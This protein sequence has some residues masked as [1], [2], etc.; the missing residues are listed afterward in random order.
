MPLR[1]GVH[2]CTGC[3]LSTAEINR[4]TGDTR[5]L[6]DTIEDASVPDPYVGLVLD[7]KYELVARLGEGG[8]GLVYRARRLHIGD[9]VAVKVLHR[10]FVA[11]PDALERFRREARSAAIIRHANIVTIHDFGEARASGAPAYIVMEL[12]RGTSLRD[13]LRQEGSLAAERAVSL[14]CDICAGVGVA[15]REGVVHRDLKPDNVIVVPPAGEGERETAKV[16]DF[17]LAKLRDLASE[18][19]L[20]QTGAVL[21]TPFYMSPEQCHG[22]ELDARSDVY[23]LGAILYEML[24]GRPPFR[25]NSLAGLISKHLHEEPPALPPGA[26]PPALEAACRR[27]LSKNP[28]ERQQDAN[29]LSREL[30]NAL[31]QPAAE[32]QLSDAASGRTTVREEPYQPPTLPYPPPR[33]KSK[34][35][36]LV[37]AGLL[38]LFVCAVVV[39]V[40]AVQY[41]RGGSPERATNTTDKNLNANSDAP[42]SQDNAALP[43]VES[44]SPQNTTPPDVAST[45]ANGKGLVGRWTGN[46]GPMSQPATLIVEKQQGSKFSGVLEQ[47][48]VRVVFEGTFDSASRKLTMKETRLLAGS[49]WSLGENSGELSADGRMMTGTGSDEVGAQLGIS[50]QWSF[51][52]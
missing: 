21:G 50:Y 8:M 28:D 44:A 27:A 41:M 5:R 32:A 40:L 4:E 20:T 9:E 29:A 7:S 15:H 11:E 35:L 47:G 2:F 42:T 10:K 30:R 1:D 25:S 6:A 33:R 49:G 23:S 3:G 51:S 52:R 38:A 31:A 17:G 39:A 46:Y 43:V 45:P 13:L 36:K 19:S 22:E 24:A 18:P 16:V 34:T 48:A 12:V 14:M 37:V 26:A